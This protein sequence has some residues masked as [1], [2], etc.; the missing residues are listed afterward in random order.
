MAGIQL[1]PQLAIV[2][3]TVATFVIGLGVAIGTG[4]RKGL[5]KTRKNEPDAGVRMAAGVLMDNVSM[6]EL[7][8]SNRDL[9]DE[10]EKN[11]R[12]VSE[13]RHQITRLIDKMR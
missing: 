10:M 11:T 5:E 2:V 4:I 6:R 12:E 13:L 9:S 1:D 7:T 3:S 8:T